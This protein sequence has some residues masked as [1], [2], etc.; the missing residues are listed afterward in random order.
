QHDV[1]GL[2]P[3]KVSEEAVEGAKLLM[4]LK[5]I[6]IH[7]TSFETTSYPTPR[8]FYPHLF[9]LR[10]PKQIMTK[11][12][13]FN[14]IMDPFD[15][16]L[17]ADTVNIKMEVFDLSPSHLTKHNMVALYPDNKSKYHTTISLI[18]LIDDGPILPLYYVADES[19]Y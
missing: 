1:S 7:S 16:A 17:F 5:S 8:D 2:A 18:R 12:N 14:S 13:S 9:S 10:H 11:V 3:I 6:N 4:V 15:L 19:F